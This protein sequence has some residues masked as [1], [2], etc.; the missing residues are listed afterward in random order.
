MGKEI[1]SVIV[2]AYNEE[3]TI[4]LVLDELLSHELVGEIIVVNDASKDSTAEK[5]KGYSANRKIKVFDHPV[6]KGK[7]A[8][9]RKGFDEA[10][11][12]IV[13]IQDA[14]LEYS[15]SDFSGIIA[16]II[17]GRADVVYGS[18]FQGGPGR[19]LY[20]R[21]QLGNKL[22]TFMSNFLTDL[23]FT[24]IET[25]YK[26]FRREVIQN[27][28]F[29]SDRF[30]IEVEITAKIAKAKLLKI[31]EVPISYNG[32]TYSEGKKITWKDGVA[33]LWHI[34]RF[35]L[36]RSPSTYYKIPWNQILKKS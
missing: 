6:N 32:R 25:C 13:I 22:I 12:P 28:I 18:R 30:G 21:H 19:V 36:L 11:F 27:I 1:L 26:A 15:P 5:L 23:N 24:D 4:S 8:A 10:S 16:P 9:I 17:S 34:I 20:Y 33:A 7:G 2:P 3:K 31:Y 35:N 29:E 14:D